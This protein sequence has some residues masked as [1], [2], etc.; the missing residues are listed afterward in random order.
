[1][2]ID[3]FIAVAALAVATSI[4]ATQWY[5]CAATK[6]R[7]VRLAALEVSV[8]TTTSIEVWCDDEYVYQATADKD[9]PLRIAGPEVL[10]EFVPRSPT[11]LRVEPVFVEE[12]AE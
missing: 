10:C 9:T 4:A 1:M 2:K 7:S 8:P 6:L 12:A 11:Q 5:G 3:Q